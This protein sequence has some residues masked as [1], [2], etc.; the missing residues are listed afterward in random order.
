MNRRLVAGFLIVCIVIAFSSCN[1]AVDGEGSSPFLRIEDSLGSEI[2]LQ[3]PPKRVAVLFSSLADVYVLAGGEV[4]ISVGES[5]QRGILSE[6]TLLVDDGAGKTINVEL[7][8]SYAPDLVLAS[9]DVPAQVEAVEQLRALGISAGCFRLESME[10]YL[11]VLRTFSSITENAD[12]YRLYGSEMVS[13]VE[14]LLSSMPKDE[15]KKR[16]LF[17]RAGSSARS[18]KAKTAEEHFA[19]QM[20]DEMNTYNIAEN[21][22]ILLDGLSVEEILREDPEM[23]FITTM[24]DEAAAIAYVESLFQSSPY[25]T[26]TAVREGKYHFLPKEL[27]QYKPN[28][29]WYSAYSYLAELLYGTS[30]D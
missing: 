29:E 7:L 4:E 1:S 10:D 15:A 14:A 27:F 18:T 22:K 21:A 3:N 13:K 26:L 2:V 8:I 5:V 16:I 6:S 9:S 20:L 25:N 23:I 12:A 19:C 17:I 30:G 24:G 11:S 28:D